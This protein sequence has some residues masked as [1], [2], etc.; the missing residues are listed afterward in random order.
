MLHG[1]DC[2]AEDWCNYT[3]FCDLA[4]SEGY[5]LIIPELG[6]S[7][8]ITQ[9]YP[10]TYFNLR[11]YPTLSWIT[12]TMIT[13]LQNKYFLFISN[14][15][16]FVAGLSTGGR[17]ATLLA[18]Y[19]PNI[20]DAVASISGEFDITSQP[21]YYL[22]YAYLGKYKDFPERWE[23]ECFAYD[24]KNYF[25]PTYI[26]HGFIDNI[27]PI[28]N[29]TDMYDSLIFYHPNIN[30]K[31]N[32]NDTAKHNYNYWNIEGNNIINFFNEI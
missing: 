13:E 15:R 25:V 5:I 21:D 14:Q 2:P 12:D 4:L 3:N 32:F 8:Y 1:W 30:F 11:K 29:S 24:C 16:N 26:A 19:L 28:K 9:I 10:E 31:T 22:Y 7:N 6:K 23:K 18:Y 17:G 27:A 20:I